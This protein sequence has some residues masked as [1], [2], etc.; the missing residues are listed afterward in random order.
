M[1]GKWLKYTLH[2]ANDLEEAFVADVL[3]STYTLG[4]IEP[5]IEV[6]V[7]D[8][9]YD[10]EEKAELPV[11]AYLFEP[12]SES[13]EQHVE[14]LK[15]FLNRWGGRVRLRET[16]QVKEENESWKE[17]FQPVQ[18]GDW[19]IAPTWTPEEALIGATHILR[20]DPGAAFGTGYHGTTQDILR[21]MQGMELHGRRVLD[22][23]AGSGILS[24]FAVKEGA[25]QP[26]YAVDINPQSEYQVHVNLKN[27]GLPHS[28]VAVVIGDAAEHDVRERLPKEVDLALVNIGGDEDI[29]MLPV[30]GE[31]IVPGGVVI[32][33]GIVEWNREKVQTAYEQAGF[34]FLEERQSEE[35]ITLL[36]IRTASE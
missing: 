17:E 10:Y 8:N 4:W 33:S 30:V 24:V 2:V 5:Q 13:E 9:G 15:L 32:L 22:I 7:T 6:L 14:R 12:M 1:Q 16:E 36:L 27:N 11:I 20:I 21:L 25:K 3:E 35:W 23:G 31:R 19:W 28:A 18:V 29:A 34:R 26:V